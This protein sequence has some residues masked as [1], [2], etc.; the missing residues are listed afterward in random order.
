MTNP[1]CPS[2]KERCWQIAGVALRDAEKR[3]RDKYEN[4]ANTRG[5]A[6]APLAFETHGRAG[7]PVL[8]LLRQIAAHTAADVGLSPADMMLDLQ[9][10][11]L[12]GNAECARATFAKAH[13]HQDFSRSRR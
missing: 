1:T 7:Q 8:A 2:R 3:K 10:T 4:Q 12:K 13:A 11:L 6:F 9:M 5:H